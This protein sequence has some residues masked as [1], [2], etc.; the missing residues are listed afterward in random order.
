MDIIQAYAPTNDKSVDI[1]EEVTK[2]TNEGEITI[3]LGDFNS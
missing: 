3:V 2:F 1:V